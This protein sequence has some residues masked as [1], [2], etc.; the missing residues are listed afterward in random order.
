MP[1]VYGASAPQAPQ[2]QPDQPKLSQ[3]VSEKKPLLQPWQAPAGGVR[4][5][6]WTIIFGFVKHTLLHVFMFGIMS[7]IFMVGYH[8]IPGIL[9]MITTF[10]FL[11]FLADAITFY[12]MRGKFA[13]DVMSCLVCAFALVS[14]AVVGTSIHLTK[15]HDYWPYE[16]KRHYTNVAPDETAASHADAS[17]IVFMEGA[18]P[19][20]SRSMG[21]KRE[22]HYYCVAPIALEA[23]YSDDQ[24]VSPKIEYW[25]VGKDCCM[26]HEGF[27]CDDANNEK[28]R[29]GL[30]K[31]PLTGYDKLMEGIMSSDEM[32]YYKQ[33]VL[34]TM[35]KF[36][37][38]SPEERLFVRYVADIEKARSDAWW[39]AWWSWGKNQLA[40]LIIWVVVGFYSV[41]IGAGDEMDSSNYLAHSV[42][43][44]QSALWQLNH[45]A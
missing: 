9:I 24:T 30:V 12:W 18:R 41:V 4:A 25:A 37:L 17:V 8:S 26:G 36:D 31:M 22:N 27:V 6:S 44:K 14:G 38:T 3:P 2:L 39:A 28:A 35:T 13:R 21:Y 7:I 15:L 43:A 19:D 45:Y 5:N 32:N 1:V 16:L 34:M 20:P 29:A 33:A 40:W 11:M 42:D 23:G 10:V